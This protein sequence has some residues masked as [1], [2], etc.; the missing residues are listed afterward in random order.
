MVFIWG[1]QEISTSYERDAAEARKDVE[2]LLWTKE[3][4]DIPDK[5]YIGNMTALK[6]S[7]FD[8][9]IPSK[10]L[11]H[12]FEDTGTTG[13]IYNVKDAYFVKG[14]CNVI[15]VDWRTLANTYPF[16]NVAAKNTKLV[17]ILTASLLNFLV[18]Q[19]NTDLKQFH[20]IGFS[21]GAQVAGH[22]GY[23]LKGKLSRITGL[24]PAGF[25]FHNVPHSERLDP[26]D[27]VF[28]DVIHSAGLWIGMDEPV[29]HVDFYPNGGHHPQPGCENE[30]IGLDCSHQ[31]AHKLLSESITSTTGFHA[32]KCESWKS[33]SSGTCDL[34]AVEQNLMGEPADST[35]HGVFYLRTYSKPP[36]AIPPAF[37]G[38]NQGSIT[39]SL[40]FAQE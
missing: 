35:K 14:P 10:I 31:R 20:P 28:V 11:I 17:G 27:A 24:D 18:E 19:G 33:F 5:L 9:D 25:L 1:N 26:S 39:N 8:K 22:L 23:K 16:Y 2:F 34:T 30:G 21:L 7:H 15:S 4:P 32:F 6:L 38:Y 29:G 36:Y 37:I 12:G 40:P 3:N 13:W